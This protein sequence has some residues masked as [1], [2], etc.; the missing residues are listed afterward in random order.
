ML[1]NF[2]SIWHKLGRSP[3]YTGISSDL[4]PIMSFLAGCRYL[5]IFCIHNELLLEIRVQL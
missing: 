1:V 4:G 2:G 5:G 3:V